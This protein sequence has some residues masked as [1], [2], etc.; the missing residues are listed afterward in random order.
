MRSGDTF[1]TFY[2]ALVDAYNNIVGSSNSNKVTIR[3]D[4]DYNQNDK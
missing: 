2:L 1:P 3:I 4:L